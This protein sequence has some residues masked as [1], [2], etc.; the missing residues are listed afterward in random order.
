MSIAQMTLVWGLPEEVGPA[1]RL[2][3]LALADCANDDGRCWPGVATVARKCAM[4]ER[5]VQRTLRDLEA[6]GRVRTE[7]RP[8]RKS[9]YMLD[10][11]T[12]DKLSPPPLTDCHPDPRQDV[13]TT[14]DRLSGGGDKSD[15]P[16]IPPHDVET[17]LKHQEKREDCLA[18]ENGDG[19]KKQRVDVHDADQ[20]VEYCCLAEKTRD[21]VAFTLATAYANRAGAFGVAPIGHQ[22]PIGRWLGEVLEGAPMPKS[23]N[24]FFQFALRRFLA[25]VAKLSKIQAEKMPW[26]T[27]LSKKPPGLG[28]VVRLKHEFGDQRRKVERD[29][30]MS[31]WVKREREMAARLHDEERENQRMAGEFLD[32]Q[33]VRHPVFG[34]GEVRGGEVI[35]SE[36]MFGEIVKGPTPL[37]EIAGELK[38]EEGMRHEVHEAHEGRLVD[39]AETAGQ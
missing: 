19:D 4:S 30:Q 21:D 12:P 10:L 3:L 17:S 38:R 5:N 34:P 20:V 33:K 9:I 35:F 2:V 1:D 6:G 26:H 29:R 15:I 16:P 37:A 23:E 7:R 27:V 24:H 25:E 11:A 31:R 36:P 39:T 22:K 28:D 8:G 13:T 14:P 32:G 18:P